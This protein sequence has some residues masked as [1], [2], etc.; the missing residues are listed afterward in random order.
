MM[1]R[2]AVVINTGYGRGAV[3]PAQAHETQAGAIA[4]LGMGL[5]REDGGDELGV[6][7]VRMGHVRGVGGVLP[8]ALAA[9][10][11]GD[12]PALREQLD[13]RGGEPDLDALVDELGGTL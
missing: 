7:S 8:A 1:K 10:R 11:R 6:G 3:P 13:D 5:G 2:T 4:L 9:A 12:A